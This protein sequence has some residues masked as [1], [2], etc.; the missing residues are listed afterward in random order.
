MA[1][2]PPN[3]LP[4]MT[5]AARAK[6]VADATGLACT[7]RDAERMR[8]E[9]F[10]TILA[11]GQGS[12][13]PPAFIVLEHEP[14]RGGAPLVFVGKGMTFDSGGISLKNGGGDRMKHDMAGAAAVI[15]AMQAV[16]ELKLP[17]RVVGIVATAE[18][19]PSGT[20]QRPDDVVYSLSGKTIEIRNTD[21]EGRLI[22]ADALEFARRL[23]PAAIV[24][25]AT[26]TGAIVTALGH[27]T[28]G[29]F[30]RH[31][32]ESDAFV[33]KLQSASDATHERVWRLP[34]WDEYDEGVKSEIA[35]IQNIGDGTAGSIAGAAFLKAFSEGYPWAHLDIAGKMLEKGAKGYAS[36]GASG[37]GARLLI[38]L[39][40]SWGD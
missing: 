13:N 30:A 12:V 19:M 35:D 37:Y 8:H 15:G 2:E 14:Q 29:L 5:L 22:L 27:E 26:L 4:P 10:N 28:A 11:V 23:K 34:L 32:E 18:N 31:D 7:I 40:R 21:A 33:A 20:A 17:R 25:L 16:A 1:N 3:F 39:A 24:N 9:G 38:Q 6:M 36:K